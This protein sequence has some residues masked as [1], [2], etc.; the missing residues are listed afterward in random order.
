L[1]ATIGARSSSGR[2][3]RK[4]IQEVDVRKAVG[5]IMNPEAPLALRLQGN[6]L[7]GVSRVYSEKCTYVL[8]DAERVRTAMKTFA[9]L[10]RAAEAVTDPKAGKAR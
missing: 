6:L 10:I 8:D 2:I 3:S 4:T 1:V 9:R 5:K 7:Y